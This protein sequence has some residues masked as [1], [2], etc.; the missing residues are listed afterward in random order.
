VI[1]L[2]KAD[3][4]DDPAGFV[5]ETEA[6]APGVPVFAISARDGTGL[7][8]L[9]RYFRRGS[10]I[11]FAGSSGVGKSTLI[12]RLFGS[13]R[14]I[15]KE[16]LDD[17][18]GRHTTTSRKLVALPSGALLIDTPGMRELQLWATPESLDHT[19]EDIQALS[20]ECRFKDC[21]HVGEPGCAVR[22]AVD[23]GQLPE[24]RYASYVK[25]QK[26]LAF[27]ERKQDVAAE[28]ES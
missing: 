27:L 7:D 17:G 14:Q 20:H 2:N 22:T 9:E 4:C 23:E 25:L 19:F 24:D 1:V 21:R 5:F 26:E 8:E 3:L 6:I 16:V 18:R 13:D 28:L 12:N 15:V 10:T 11:V